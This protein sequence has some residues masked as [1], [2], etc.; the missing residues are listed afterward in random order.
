MDT[1]TVETVN[2][3]TLSKKI[4]EA[5]R[6]Y[7]GATL[8]TMELLDKVFSALI[9]DQ[10]GKVVDG[11]LVSYKT[12]RACDLK[13]FLPKAS[14]IGSGIGLCTKRVFEM[15]RP[16]TQLWSSVLEIHGLKIPTLIGINEN[17]RLAKQVVIASVEVEPWISYMDFYNELEEIIVKVSLFY[18]Q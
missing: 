2:Y 15:E 14:L 9:G 8:T 3:S 1:L 5:C 13:V 7:D 12:V 10:S 4:L 16:A 17:E 6:K 11:E 18:S